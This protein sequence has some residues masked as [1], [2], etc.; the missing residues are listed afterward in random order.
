MADSIEAVEAV[1]PAQ[2]SRLMGEILKYKEEDLD[3]TWFVDQRIVA[4]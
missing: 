4:K 2:A 1:D 3:A